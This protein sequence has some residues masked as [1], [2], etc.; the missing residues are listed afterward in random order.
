VFLRGNL[1]DKDLVSGRKGK[2]ESNSISPSGMTT[3]KQVQRQIQ[4]QVQRNL[5]K[6][7]GENA[8]TGIHHFVQDDGVK[9]RVDESGG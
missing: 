3:E 6:A 4:R 5:Q 2:D 7:K 8:N 9:R 1:R